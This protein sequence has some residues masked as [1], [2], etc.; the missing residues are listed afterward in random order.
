M[1]TPTP[2][3]IILGYDQAHNPVFGSMEDSGL[4][5]EAGNHLFFIPGGA[6]DPVSNAQKFTPRPTDCL[7]AYIISAESGVMAAGLGAGA[8][9][10]SMR[11]AP[12][13]PGALALVHRVQVAVANAG[14]AFTAGIGSL[15]MF[16]ARAFNASDSGGTAQTLTGNNG[17]LRTSFNT[18]LVADM[19]IAST[20]TLTAGTR[21]LDA[22]DV[23][24]VAF[25]VPATTTNNLLLALT[26]MLTRS[27][28][29]GDWPLVLANNEGF[30][31]QA[32]LPATGTW[33]FQVVVD[34]IEVASF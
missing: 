2:T 5:D 1:T 18:S 6:T 9:V 28:A 33:I 7:G 13:T 32:S 23:G 21:T 10:F 3:K 19:R 17:K 8:P 12:T 20:A 4:T 22:V 31:I 26:D 14:T 34:W 30:V 24:L 16:V 15:N 25:P 11:W 29:D 27:G